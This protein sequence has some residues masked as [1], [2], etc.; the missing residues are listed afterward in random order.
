M[1]YLKIGVIYAALFGIGW[2]GG[3]LLHE[4]KVFTAMGI[5]SQQFWGAYNACNEKAEDKCRMY[6][7]FIGVQKQS[8]QPKEEDSI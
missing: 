6:G 5:T 3:W 2:T 4:Q 7:G 8:P 1:K